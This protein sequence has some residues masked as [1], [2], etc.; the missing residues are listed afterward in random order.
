MGKYKKNKPKREKKEIVCN[1]KLK[2]KMLSFEFPNWYNKNQDLII[3]PTL[4]FS[5]YSGSIAN[6]FGYTATY[7]DFGFLYAGSTAFGVGYPTILGAYQINFAGGTGS[8][9]TDIAITNTIQAVVLL[10]T[11]LI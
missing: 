6:N 3:D 10:F 8:I 7:D 2:G 4:V 5:T 11:L 9:G 1:Y